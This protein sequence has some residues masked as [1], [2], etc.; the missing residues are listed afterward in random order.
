MP[1]LSTFVT[2]ITQD[3]FIP[4]VIDNVLDSNVL[5]MRLMRNQ[6]T[7]NGG[8]QIVQPVNLEAYSQLGSYSGFDVLSTTHQNTRQT[9]TFNPSQMYVSMSI[10]GIQKATNSGDAA[11]VDLIATEMEQR[12]KDLKN[13]FG[14]QVYSDGT[15]NGG[16]DI[17]GI[18]A[19]I[20][21]ATS[22]AS[23]GGI[24]RS[25]YTNWKATRTAQSGSLSLADLAADFDAAEVNGEVPTLIVTTPS[26]FSI[27]EALLTP[28]V[29]HQFSMND[30]R[31]SS[32]G[33][34]RVGGAVAAN[35]GFRALT[36][37][38]IPVV[39]DPKC[40]SGNIFFINENHLFFMRLPQPTGFTV[41]SEREGFGWTGWKEPVNQDAVTGRLQWYGQLLS[42]SPRTMSRRTGV[43]S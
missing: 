23:Y 2:S 17:L 18:L 12:M 22:V 15:G 6:R 16:K 11:V 14:N 26:V 4:R 24:S 5:T 34:A 31:M 30:F 7:W 20:D 37:R 3:R 28:T 13:E 33:M 42:D 36:F 8:H 21:D 27:Y 32:D 19:A 38:G 41:E 29:S 9:A 1:A 40:T 43:T 39:S 25:T 35:Q 10:S